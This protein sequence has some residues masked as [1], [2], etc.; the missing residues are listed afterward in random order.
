MHLLRNLVLFYILL[1]FLFSQGTLNSFGI[2]N[3]QKWSSPSQG[4]IGSIGLVPSFQSGVSLSNPATWSNLK[5]T[6]LSVSYNGLESRINKNKANNSFSN[7]QSAQLI[8]PIKERYS[9]GIELH[10]Y[11]YQQVILADT[12]YDDILVF[13]DTISI[14]KEYEQAGGIMAFDLSMSSLIFKN[15]NIGLTIQ[16]LFG[17]SRQNNSLIFDQIPYSQTSRLNYSGVNSRIYISQRSSLGNFYFKSSF[18]LN[19]LE[20]IYTKMYPFD[21]TNKNG[22]HDFNYNTL[23]PGYDF[24]HPND[25][26]KANE[27]RITN[28]HDQSSVGIGLSRSIL[29]RIQLSAEYEMSRDN[30]SFDIRLPNS[31]NYRVKSNDNISIG[32]I[33]FPNDL[34]YNFTDNF[35]FRSGITFS[36]ISFDQ[37]DLTSQ[38]R[39]NNKN[40]ITQFG[41]TIGFGYKFKAVGNQI[42]FTYYSGFR[43]YPDIHSDEKL[44]QFQIGLNIADIWFTKRRQR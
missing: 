24:P 10:P 35:I 17:S 42:D 11:S 1:P 26:P 15:I 23:N 14:R 32:F 44:R 6:L 27:S 4:G 19:P 29:N 12:L 33:W 3:H 18:S 22:Y 2:G 5:F 34:S 41:Y 36:S 31:F 20:A 16:L 8:V 25:V 28:I 13:E 30:S 9:F 38:S 37:Y 40:D 39:M 43:D 7:L 21:D